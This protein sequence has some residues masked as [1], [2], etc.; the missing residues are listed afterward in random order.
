MSVYSVSNK[1]LDAYDPFWICRLLS[2]KIGTVAILLFMCNAFLLSPQSPMTYILTTAVGVLGSEL[3]P[4]PNTQRKVINFIFIVFLLASTTMI[5]GM[6]SYFRVGLF[7]V[8]VG[9]SFLVLRYMATNPKVAAIPTVMILWG[10]INLNGGATDMNAVA[11]NYL[12]FF[13]FGLMGV[14][15]II[16]FP[17]FNSKIFDSAFLRILAADVDNVGNPHYRN[18]HPSVLS[19]LTVMRSKLPGL[20]K[21]YETLYEHIIAFQN[22]FMKPHELDAESRLLAKSALSELIQS[23]EKGIPFSL[24]T[25]NVQKIN[26]L[27]PDIYDCLAQLADGYNQ[28]KV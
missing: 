2:L 9:F 15:T 19:A 27:H 17:N 13:E 4:A 10:I 11:N 20:P 16:F 14:I 22:A 26:V 18:S 12:Y 25:N 28:C 24:A 21:T 7:F 1:Y 5:F 6:A 23:V 8:V 3:I